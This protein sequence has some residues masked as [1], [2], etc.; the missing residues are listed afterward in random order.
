MRVNNVVVEESS[1]ASFDVL[2]LASP[3]CSYPGCIM[4]PFFSSDQQD[5]AE[6]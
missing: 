1:A 5:H 3:A 4:L 2:S 6:R